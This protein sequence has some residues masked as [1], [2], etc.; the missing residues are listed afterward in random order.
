MSKSRKKNNKDGAN[1]NRGRAWVK[2]SLLVVTQRLRTIPRQVRW[3]M[4]ILAAVAYS[5]VF[6]SFFVEPSGFRWRALYGDPNYPETDGLHGCDISHHQGTI[7]W[8]RLRNAMINREP[9]QFVMIKATEGSDYVDEKFEENFS[10]AKRVGFVRGAYHFWSVLSDAREQ[11]AFFLN[12]VKLEIGDLPPVL[13][14]ESKLDAM[15]TEDFQREILTW[16]HIVEDKYHAKPIIYTNY[17]FKE[18]YLSDERFD[19]YPYWI[20]HYYVE[21]VQYKGKWKFWQHTD[22]GRLPGIKGYVDLD[23]YNG[24]FYD[25]SM[26]CISKTQVDDPMKGELN[27]PEDSDST[28]TFVYEED[29]DFDLRDTDYE[30]ND[31]DTHSPD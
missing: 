26:L 28:N 29:S 20:A 12:N 7:D 16:L 31:R 22:V 3:G 13:D 24:S 21:E 25:L 23:I 6:Y 15:S 27:N 1:R 8:T 19:D 17:K 18:A 10:E 5:W 30:Q 11:A 4:A 2:R 9:L 14:V